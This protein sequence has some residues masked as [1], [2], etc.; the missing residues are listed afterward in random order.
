M[1]KRQIDGQVERERERERERVA[2]SEGWSKYVTSNL[3]RQAFTFCTN[4][5]V[6]YYLRR[7]RKPFSMKSVNL[8]PITLRFSMFTN[9]LVLNFSP[10]GF[11]YIHIC[12]YSVQ[13]QLY[14]Y[15]LIVLPTL[16]LYPFDVKTLNIIHKSQSSHIVK[17]LHRVCLLLHV[18]S[19]WPRLLLPSSLFFS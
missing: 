10:I 18:F 15:V 3:W 8:S 19:Y 6:R 2:I 17:Q 5:R 16:Q 1:R 13:T 11:R 7:I 12:T 9:V 14:K 4:V